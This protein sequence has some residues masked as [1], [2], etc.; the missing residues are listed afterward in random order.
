MEQYGGH[1]L[2]RMNTT[3]YSKVQ[4]LNWKTLSQEAC[5]F[6]RSAKSQQGE[7]WMNSYGIARGKLLEGNSS[8]AVH[9]I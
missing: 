6:L 1:N 2:V 8:A 5:F 3:K 4:H 9:C 7:Q